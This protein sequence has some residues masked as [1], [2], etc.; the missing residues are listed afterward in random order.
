MTF[1]IDTF[2]LTPAYGLRWINGICVPEG[3]LEFFSEEHTKVPE[4]A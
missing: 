2:A 4:V 1:H 3:G